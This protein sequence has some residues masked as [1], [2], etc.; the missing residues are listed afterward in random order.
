MHPVEALGHV[1]RL[2][3]LQPADEMPGDRQV[4]KDVHFRHGF[5]HIVFAEM[6][7][8]GDKGLTDL[9]GRLRLGNRDESHLAAIPL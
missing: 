6:S 5:L 7:A 2:V 8:A 1:T 3:G 4:G 9:F